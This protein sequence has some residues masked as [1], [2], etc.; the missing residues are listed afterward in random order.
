MKKEQSTL[1]LSFGIAAKLFDDANFMLLQTTHKE[2]YN[3][4]LTKYKYNAK[5]MDAPQRELEY[6]LAVQRQVF[7]NIGNQQG[8][9][10]SIV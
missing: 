5:D 10:Y 1:S 3:E 7:N 2:K 6:K 4:E 8:A 9:D